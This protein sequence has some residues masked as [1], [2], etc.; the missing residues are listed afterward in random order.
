MLELKIVRALEKM[1]VFSLSDVSKITGSRNYSKQLLSRLVKNGTITH[2]FR[3]KYSF[4]SDALIVAGFL[5]PPS[6]VSCA[7]ALSF[8]GLISQMPKAV[9]VM[10]AKRAKTIKIP[11]FPSKC[12]DTNNPKDRK[13][14]AEINLCLLLTLIP[15]SVFKSDLRILP[16]Q[17]FIFLKF[18]GF[19]DWNKLPEHHPTVQES[20]KNQLLCRTFPYPR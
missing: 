9:F 2:F 17:N 20:L 11:D 6:Y 15:S 12:S 5:Q 14:T 10:T 8:Y 1:A 16:F 4:H 18:I 13:R 3:D 7:S 19:G